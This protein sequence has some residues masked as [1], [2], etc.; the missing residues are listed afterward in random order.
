[1]E[2]Q[3]GGVYT[4]FKRADEVDAAGC[5]AKPDGVQ[6]PSMWVPYFGSE[7]IDATVM[8]AASLGAAVYLP[9]MDV[10]GVGRV[11]ML[12]DPTGATFGLFRPSSS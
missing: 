6:M 9:G 8:Q 4:L 11:A 2:L 10:A 5:V 3:A 12:A 1:M 7:D